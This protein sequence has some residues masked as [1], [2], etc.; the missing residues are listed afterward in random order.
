M[1]RYVDAALVRAAATDPDQP[2]LWPVLTGPSAS[3]QSW[4]TWLQQIWQANDFAAAVTDASADLAD[5]VE[6]IRSGRPVPEA[7]ARRT[8]LA[9][10]RYLLRA[11]TRAT[12]FGL[13]AGVAAARIGPAPALQVRTA[14]KATTRPDAT[15]AHTVIDRFELD[16]RLR[17]RVM[18][19]ASTLA[20]ERDDRVVLEHRRHD[21][22][23]LDHV[24]VRASGPVRRA[25]DVARTPIG[26]NDLSAHL[27]AHY[28]TTAT[29]T[30]DKLLEGLVGNG[31][32]LTNLRPSMI[33]PDPL[34]ALNRQAHRLTPDEAA[35]VREPAKTRS[36]LRVDWD[37]VIPDVVARE[38]ASAATALAR[39]APRGE[40][41]GWR[42]WHGQFLER[43]GPCAVVRVTD[44]I[45]TLGYP[46]GYRGS[47]A[48]TTAPLPERDSRLIKLA[49]AAGMRRQLEVN[50]DD[51]MLEDLAAVD[52][53]RPVQPSTEVTSRIHAVSLP[54][55]ERGEFTLHVVGVSRAAGATAGRALSL[56]DDMDQRRMTGTYATVPGVHR[57]ALL[58]QISSTPLTTRAENVAR[59][60][61]TT[62]LVISLGDYQAPGTN[63]V[64]LNDLAVTADAERLHLL[65]LSRRRPLHTVLMNAVDLTQH[66]HP[67]ARFLAE[68][69]VALATPCTGFM[70]GSAA[71][72][73]PFLPALR[74]KRTIL[75]PARWLLA[76][77]D[78]PAPL[79]PWPQWNAAL[80]QWCEDMHLPQRVYLSDADQALALDLSEPSH[81]AL[82]RSHVDR[83]GTV[84]LRSAPQ[85]GDL[86]WAG[87]RAHE[88]VVPLVAVQDMDPVRT[89]GPVAGRE[90]GRLPGCDDRIFLKL[91]GHRDRQ[92]AILLRHLPTLLDELGV[93]QSWFMRYQD[94]DDQ[95]RL[96]LTC[97]PDT[98]GPVLE[99]VSAWTRQLRHH[100]LISHASVATDYPEIGRYSGR[101]GGRT[102][103]DAAE[104]YFA[105][106]SAAVLAQLAVQD[107]KDA[108]DARAVTAASM[109]D[110]A[111]GL[112]RSDTSAMHW[113]IEHTRTTATAPPR[114]VYR[115][116]VDLVNANAPVLDVRVT[117]AWTARRTAL[118]AYR[119]ALLSAGT[120][121]PQD[122]VLPSLLHLHHV[123]LHGPDRSEEREHLHLARAA[124]L[125]WTARARKRTP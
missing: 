9:V 7:D 62:D 21:D 54:A 3:V 123:R 97:L 34:A 76:R 55:L 27:H 10:L 79:T 50:L 31:F 70:W 30:V 49:H 101:F 59:A 87:G 105:A 114:D 85:R 12:P 39:L 44:A 35:A 68:A 4:R 113:L 92:G 5:R 6:Q 65:S 60:L 38:A 69:P 124:A 115:Q 82:L 16:E 116:A 99:K 11:R 32:L 18:V 96:R 90:H 121:R 45:D 74:Y 1:Y 2:M 84:N 23:D 22:N 61:Q 40:L 103:M 58:A 80:T 78:L 112:L 20:T 98:L 102:A 33:C 93:L 86:G 15:W 63:I 52:A 108:P 56:L 122:D 91:Y 119:R 72:N 25:L 71:S 67:L 29:A 64:P 47:R 17:S 109:V 48:P 75:S 100:R 81:R 41:A 107:D 117:S 111:A 51:A 125:S 66:T 24:Q 43:Y 77:A 14:H 26:W 88:I 13:F 106:D 94:P 83:H 53:D 37:L 46:A 36:D 28:P 118:D 95:I 57:G 104:A 8:V 73:L 89:F 120:P 42:D 19:Q 110:I